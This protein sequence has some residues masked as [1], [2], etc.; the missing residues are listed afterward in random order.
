[1]GTTPQQSPEE[2]D[3]APQVTPETP[4]TPEIEAIDPDLVAVSPV[5]ESPWRM[6][7]FFLAALFAT[8]TAM[9]ALAQVADPAGI[10]YGLAPFTTPLYGTPVINIAL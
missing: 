3:M 8:A 6:P 1:M 7:G 4:E 5:P 2:A 10:T 9:C